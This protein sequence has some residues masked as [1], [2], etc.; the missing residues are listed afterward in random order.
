MNNKLKKE[1]VIARNKLKQVKRNLI[2]YVPVAMTIMASWFPSSSARPNQ[3]DTA[4]NMNKIENI[5]SM[6]AKDKKADAKEKLYY[7]LADAKSSEAYNMPLTMVSIM[8]EADTIK[9]TNPAAVATGNGYYGQNQLS[10]ENAKRFVVYAL[11][12][13]SSEDKTI[14]S[15]FLRGSTT[16]AGRIKNNQLIDNF[17]KSLETK[18]KTIDIANSYLT[19]NKA[20]TALLNNI[21]VSNF[22]QNWKIVNDGNAIKDSK[23][24][25][26]FVK[27]ATDL[28]SHFIYEVYAQIMSNNMQAIQ[29]NNP[30]IEFDKVHPA[31][32]ATWLAIAVKQGN[33]TKINNSLKN[34]KSAEDLNT[35]EYLRRYCGVKFGKVFVEA[36]KMIDKKPSLKTIYEMSVLLDNRDMYNAYE[37][38]YGEDEVQESII[39]WTPAVKLQKKAN[40]VDLQ[41][42]QELSGKNLALNNI[43]DSKEVVV[44][45]EE[46]IKRKQFQKVIRSRSKSS[47]A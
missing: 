34:F 8:T 24:K 38:A 31:V 25:E 26:Q 14:F 33:G 40:K 12:N 2:K 32:Y 22:T 42:I 4:K 15:K 10:L 3:P 30:H 16:E 47:R 28:Q 6:K 36:S 43:P 17:E 20:Y 7:T 44:S 46:L 39:A 45:Q 9:F 23:K 13:S 19:S 35:K 29:K 21:D 1:L 5:R 18:E 27:N 41:K 11:V 37:A